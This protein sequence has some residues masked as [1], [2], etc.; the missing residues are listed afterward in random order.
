LGKKKNKLLSLISALLFLVTYIV[1]PS[2]SV[3]AVEIAIN[4]NEDTTI[5]LSEGFTGARKNVKPEGEGWTITRNGEKATVLDGYDTNG[6][7]GKTKPSLGFGRLSGSSTETLETPVFNL[8]STGTLSFWYKGQV[9]NGT[10]TSTLKLEV[11]VNE[12]WQEI[13]GPDITVTSEST[14][15]VSLEKGVTAIRFTFNKASGNLAIEDI[16]ISCIGG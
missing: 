7:Y 14:F 13:K 15:S 4:N 6:N 5:L 2:I 1:M 11:K 10:I 9:G 16:E 3:Y 12:V 8:P